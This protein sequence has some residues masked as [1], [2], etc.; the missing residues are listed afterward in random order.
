MALRV[1]ATSSALIT[2]P[3]QRSHSAFFAGGVIML[4][5]GALPLAA[6]TAGLAAG[7]AYIV[8]R[9][10]TGAPVPLACPGP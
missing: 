9:C 4:T 1:C 10:A 2:G 7:T 3:R 6:V 8:Y 5:Y